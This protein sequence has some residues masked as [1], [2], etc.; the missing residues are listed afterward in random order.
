MIAAGQKAFVKINGEPVFVLG[1]ESESP[2]AEV[3]TV[4]RFCPSDQ[5]TSNYVVDTFGTEELE[6][7]EEKVTRENAEME[8]IRTVAQT[9]RGNQA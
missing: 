4:R 9:P 7:F 2:G 1:V 3:A 5:G 8:F 6:S